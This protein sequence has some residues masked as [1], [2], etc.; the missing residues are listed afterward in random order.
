MTPET[1]TLPA[2]YYTDPD[3]F[4]L[5]RERMFARMWVCAGRTEEIAAPGDFVL[6]DVAG[7]SVIITRRKDG[8]LAAHY[9]V[10]RHRGTRLCTDASGHFPD[11]IQCPYHGWT[12]DLDGRLLGAPHMDAAPGFR[13][14]ENA[15]TPVAVGEWD[16]HLFVA[17]HPA[18]PPLREQLV[19]LPERF[20]AWHMGE[21][22]RAYRLTYDVK[23]NWK[24]LMLNYSECLHCPLIH[25]ALQRNADYLSGDNE[26]ATD[27]WFGG[28]MSLRDGIFTMSRD[29]RQ[30][31]P[32]LPGLTEDQRHHG[33]YY[34]VLPNLLLSLHP[35]YVMT[36]TL[37]PMACDLTRIVCEWHFHPSEHENPLFDPSDVIDFWDET[38]RQDWHVSE[39]SQA[40]I[41][42]R[43]YR[44]GIYSPREGLLWEFDRAVSRILD[45]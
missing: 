6:R 39:L 28:A 41:S 34:A 26:P 13:R 2:R 23:A 20:S 45:A 4:L 24:L 38:N 31:R 5:E 43:A 44:P 29:G 37:W 15:L 12:Y 36:H 16:G 10:C 9:N 7:E 30:R 18:A 42:S 1:R 33:Y 27:T 8:A 35:D 25:P 40:G 14:D 19:G 22:R 32:P 17:L 11:R 3:L 21:L